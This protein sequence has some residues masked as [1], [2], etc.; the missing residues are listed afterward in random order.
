VSYAAELERILAELRED[1]CLEKFNPLSTKQLGQQL[2][3]RGLLPTRRT[4]TGKLSTDSKALFSFR[5]E[6]FVAKIVAYREKQKL[7]STYIE[8]LGKKVWTDGRLHPSWNITATPT[9][10]FGTKPAIQNWPNSMR[11]MLVAPPG[12]IWIGADYK[13]LELRLIAQLSGQEDLQELFLQEQDVHLVNAREVYFAKIWDEATPEQQAKL[14]KLGKNVTFGDNYMA[15]AQTL[16][17]TVRSQHPSVTLQEVSIMQSL[18]RNRYPRKVEFARI[19]QREACAKFELRT[20]WLGRRR[21]WPLGQVPDTEASNHPIQGGAGDIAGEAAI[22]W[23]Q[24][25][26]D[27]GDY[28]TRIFPNLQIHD[29]YYAYAREDYAEQ[30]VRDLMECMH[31]EKSAVSPV[32]GK[33]YTMVYSVEGQLGYDLA[34]MKEV[35][36]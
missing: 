25:L 5:D 23:T 18:L 27:K 3:N 1:T 34:H 30:A 8:G 2:A 13:A 11:G 6:P 21:R 22:R 16:F 20:P 19:M 35:S 10:R 29:A 12:F 33:T 28:H 15:G 9:G 36:T 14:R 31:C 26:K 32:T 24:F 17:E 4:K 7:Y